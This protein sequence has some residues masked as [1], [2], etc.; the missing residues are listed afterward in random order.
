MRTIWLAL[1]R[2]YDW[3]TTPRLEFCVECDTP[4]DA[5]NRMNFPFD[6]YC[7]RCY[8]RRR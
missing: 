2:L 1:R 6:A 7:E 8:F 3:A 5:T 4:L